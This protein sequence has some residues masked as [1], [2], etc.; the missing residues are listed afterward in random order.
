MHAF[1]LNYLKLIEFT[2]K[3]ILS[4]YQPVHLQFMAF[5]MSVITS[6]FVDQFGPLGPFGWS[7]TVDI[8]KLIYIQGHI[9]GQILTS[10]SCTKHIYSRLIFYSISMRRLVH[11]TT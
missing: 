4:D 11:P 5:F 3:I 2:I 1:K 7:A 9:H 6:A 10:G 8:F